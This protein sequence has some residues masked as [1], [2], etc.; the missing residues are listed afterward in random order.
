[1]NNEEFDR[2]AEFIV[3]QQAQFAVDI[4]KLKEAQ[5]VTEQ[6][7]AKAFK[8]AA[9]ASEVAERAIEAVALTAE[10]VTRFQTLTHEGFRFVFDSF[11]E[12]D[13]KINV[14]VNSQIL[15]DEKL[16]NLT[17]LMDRHI[18]EGHRGLNGA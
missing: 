9:H 7:M 14:L 5:A 1:M 13:A 8:A 10:T 17:A 11:K 18:R 6:E 4:Q 15:T 12:T 2:K 3:N 16:R